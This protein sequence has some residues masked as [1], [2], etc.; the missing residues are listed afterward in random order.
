MMLNLVEPQS[1]GIGG[2]AFALY[3]DESQKQLTSMGRP[4]KAPALADENY[5]LD[6]NGNPIKCGMPSRG[7]GRS[8]FPAR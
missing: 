4:R 8:A 7:G 2:G 5:W 1:S 3:W 6:A